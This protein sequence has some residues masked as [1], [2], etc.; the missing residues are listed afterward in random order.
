MVIMQPVSLVRPDNVPVAA[1]ET[2]PSDFPPRI[3]VYLEGYLRLVR[4]RRTG[5]LCYPLTSLP[6]V[7]THWV[8]IG[9]LA[10]ERER[11]KQRQNQ[12]RSDQQDL[13]SVYGICCQVLV[14]RQ[15]AKT[16]LSGEPSNDHHVRQTQWAIRI[17]QVSERFN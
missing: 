3:E 4:K 11:E 10:R 2:W 6:Q 16:G 5:A 15:P 17:P 1:Q 7:T 9:E 8:L 13:F 14:V 12:V